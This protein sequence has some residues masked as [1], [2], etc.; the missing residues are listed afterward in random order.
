M[1]KLIISGALALTV[2]MSSYAQVG[3]GTLFMGGRL[4]FMQSQA[5][6]K[7][8]G[9]TTD[10][11][12]ITHFGIM[13]DVGY[14]LTDN[15]AAGLGIG[16]T[17]AVSNF[18][19]TQG[20]VTTKVKGKESMFFL[21]PFLRYYK[22]MG[23]KGGVFAQFDVGIGSGK[24][25]GETTTGN[26]TV[27]TTDEKISA[28]HV[29]LRPGV[30][31]FVTDKIGLEATVGALGFFQDKE[32]D[33]NSQNKDEETNTSIGFRFNTGLFNQSSILPNNPVFNIGV[34][35]YFTK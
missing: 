27:T 8:G 25:F 14:F 9:T 31:F 15:I 5:K 7:S 17:S 33:E 11:P 4:E 23:D 22:F 30:V 2:T 1:K 29:A 16:Y 3:Q 12:K 28:F 20:Q 26:V 19:N 24:N 34:K 13:P 32:V 10:G 18:E 6:N 35:Y 21:L